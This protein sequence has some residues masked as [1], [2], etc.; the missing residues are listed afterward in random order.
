MLSKADLYSNW[1]VVSAEAWMCEKF[2]L[3]G[4]TS[5]N[6]GTIV[7]DMMGS[8]SCMDSCSTFWR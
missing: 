4:K 3:G 1:F 5:V 2:S 7:C 8:D 6:R